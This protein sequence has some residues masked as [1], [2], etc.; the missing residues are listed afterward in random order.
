MEGPLLAGHGKR[1]RDDDRE[2][3]AAPEVVG[4]PGIVTNHI[5]SSC[6]C[7][8]KVSGIYKKKKKEIPRRGGKRIR[9][10]LVIVQSLLIVCSE[11]LNV[12]PTEKKRLKRYRESH[13]QIK[14]DLLF[15]EIGTLM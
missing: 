4:Q 9:K 3:H 1:H 11:E 7:S 12:Y 14:Q 15:F 5:G 6:Y 13:L 8:A 2:M 10:S